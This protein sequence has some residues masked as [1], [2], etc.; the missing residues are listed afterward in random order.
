MRKIFRKSKIREGVLVVIEQLGSLTLGCV[1]FIGE[2]K[3]R[4]NNF[5]TMSSHTLER[6]STWK[7]SCSELP[8]DPIELSRNQLVRIPTPREARKLMNHAINE[9]KKRRSDL[10][11]VFR[12]EASLLDERIVFLENRVRG[13]VPG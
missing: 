10:E 11:S 5:F 6:F 9:A 4:T 1:S 13:I 8:L 3:F 7:W 12:R 2:S